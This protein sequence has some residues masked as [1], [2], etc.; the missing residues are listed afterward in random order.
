MQYNAIS[1][2]LLY[3]PSKPQRF[4]AGYIGGSQPYAFII[5]FSYPN[6]YYWNIPRYRYLIKCLIFL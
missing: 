4:K 6:E 1:M 3:T 2:G 5:S